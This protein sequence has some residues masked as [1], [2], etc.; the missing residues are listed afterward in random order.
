MRFFLF[1]LTLMVP[2][3]KGSGAGTYLNEMPPAYTEKEKINML[4]ARVENLQ[5]ARFDR[6][7][8]LYSAERAATYLR[9][10]WRRAGNSVHTARDFIDKIGSRSSTTGNYHYIV[11]ANGTRMRLRD[12][13]LKELEEI[14]QE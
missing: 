4:I 7:G 11:Y 8:S 12:F 10:K 2:V 1:I 6:N 9:T 3:I 13:L 14:E 5:G